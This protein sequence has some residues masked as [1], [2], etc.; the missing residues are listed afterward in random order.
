MLRAPL[1]LRRLDHGESD[2]A[3]VRHRPQ[4]DELP[5]GEGLL[6]RERPGPLRRAS[7]CRGDQKKHACR[8]SL[9]DRSRFQD[10]AYDRYRRAIRP[11]A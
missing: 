6:G 10:R 8:S 4:V 9:H 11:T 5:A 3:S 1:P 2:A 7:R